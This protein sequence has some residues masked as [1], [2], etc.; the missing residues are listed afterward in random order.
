MR[1]WSIQIDFCVFAASR[2][3]FLISRTSI[4]IWLL[5][6]FIQKDDDCACVWLVIDFQWSKNGEA[7][8]R[9]LHD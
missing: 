7:G 2:S 8:S 6:A 3:R 5:F 1:R 9:A 4:L